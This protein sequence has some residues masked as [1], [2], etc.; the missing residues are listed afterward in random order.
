MKDRTLL[1]SIIVACSVHAFALFAGFGFSRE[2]LAVPVPS[3][4]VS[5]V[6]PIKTEQV[7]SD[8]ERLDA[9]PVGVP[10]PAINSKRLSKPIAA[11]K[12]ESV[13][14]PEPAYAVEPDSETPVLTAANEV[15]PT[16]PGNEVTSPQ[17]LN[18]FMETGESSANGANVT[19]ASRRGDPV[20]RPHGN[21]GGS[22]EPG[23][24]GGLGGYLTAHPPAYMSN[25][26][27]EYPRDARR[28]GQEGTVVLLVEVLPNGNVRE[29]SID[30]SSGFELLDSAAIKAVRKWRFVPAKN[31]TSSTSAWVK[32]PVEFS[33]KN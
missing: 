33:L 21:I 16:A 20:G 1:V 14:R 24:Q 4:E 6:G 10:K 27:P 3:I 19:D 28:N 9:K 18:A 32:I 26:K 30:K 29:I 5:L 15:M 8:V 2:T 11:P 17:G 13:A 12:P 22:L 23:A 25:P 31:G 7:S